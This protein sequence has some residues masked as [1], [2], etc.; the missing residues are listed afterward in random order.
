MRNAMN[1]DSVGIGNNPASHL[2]KMASVIRAE[3]DAE[4]LG[5]FLAEAGDELYVGLAAGN[6]EVEDLLLTLAAHA[7]RAVAEQDEFAVL[8]EEGES[9]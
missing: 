3:H 7:D 4:T 8:T 5:R 1:A 9:C 6:A 2:E